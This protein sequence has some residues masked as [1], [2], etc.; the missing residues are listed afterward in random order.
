MR[1]T[2][3]RQARNGTAYSADG[4][5]AKPIDRQAGPFSI[6]IIGANLQAARIVRGEVNVRNGR[7]Q[8][9]LLPRSSCWFRLNELIF[10]GG[11][12][13][14]S[15]PRSATRQRNGVHTRNLRPTVRAAGRMCPPQ[16]W[17]WR[18][19]VRRPDGSVIL[20]PLAALSGAPLDALTICVC[21]G[22][23]PRIAATIT[24]AATAVV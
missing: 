4:R 20:E 13:E 8:R 3:Y 6:G 10:A 9:P 23:L 21:R 7:E 12:V 14:V 17:Y 1:V 22:R 18:S 16:L 2:R 11:T 24:V 19:R 5:A 15:N